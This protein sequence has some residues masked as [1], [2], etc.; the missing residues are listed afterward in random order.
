ML[1]HLDSVTLV[2]VAT[3]EDEATAKA[4]EFSTRMLSFGKVLLFSH[5]NSF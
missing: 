2:A 3:T 5:Y 1:K 4:L